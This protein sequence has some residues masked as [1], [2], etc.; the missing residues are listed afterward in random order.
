MRYILVC[1]IFICGCCEKGELAKIPVVTEQVRIVFEN[2]KVDTINVVHRGILK[3]D[4]GGRLT[5][6][7]PCTIDNVYAKD[8]NAF[9]VLVKGEIIQNS[10]DELN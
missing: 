1:L 8:I 3:M 7:C 4:A 6:D 5:D 9:S 2:G 10:E